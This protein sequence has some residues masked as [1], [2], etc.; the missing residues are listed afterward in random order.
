M[1][2]QKTIEYTV[3][4]ITIHSKEV[5]QNLY[6]ELFDDF[7]KE[8]RELLINSHGLK[9][10]YMEP[11]DTENTKKGFIGNV[12][13][14]DRNV[15]KVLNDESG[16]EL[17]DAELAKYTFPEELKPNPKL[18]RIILDASRNKVLCEITEKDDNTI[19]P[20]VLLDFFRVLVDNDRTRKKFGTIEIKLIN[21]PI[22]LE[23]IL[24]TKKLTRLEILI[25][26]SN[27]EK[28]ILAKSTQIFE[29]KRKKDHFLSLNEQNIN[30]IKIAMKH[31][32]VKCSIKNKNDRIEYF[33]TS[34]DHPF[35]KKITYDPKKTDSY[36]VIKANADDIFKEAE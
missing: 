35:T 30:D 29:A 20:N 36:Y 1:A 32:Y 11:L 2:T 26:H 21:K 25:D 9:L 13:K 5:D 4:D 18:F 17:S 12:L 33:S 24:E 8:K 31:G 14:W 3:L 22:K 28:E 15:S 10:I 19:S 7:Q 34:L 16:K 6:F 27:N 23:T